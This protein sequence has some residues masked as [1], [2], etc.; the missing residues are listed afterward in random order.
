MIAGFLILSALDVIVRGATCETCK[1]GDKVAITGCLVVVPDVPSM[2][3]PSEAKQ[4]LSQFYG[5]GA[6]SRTN[7]HTAFVACGLG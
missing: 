7:V 4:V 3:R 6:V 1:A 2:L 5:F